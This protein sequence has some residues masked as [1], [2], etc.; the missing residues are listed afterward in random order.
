MSDIDPLSIRENP[1]Q[2]N[3]KALSPWGVYDNLVV[4]VWGIKLEENCLKTFLFLSCNALKKQ[5]D[6]FNELFFYWSRS[7]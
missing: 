3:F 2:R 7:R 6:D 4:N 5:R 1:Q